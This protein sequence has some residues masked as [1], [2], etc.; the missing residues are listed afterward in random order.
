MVLTG[1]HIS[2]DTADVYKY[3]VVRHLF[4]LYVMGRGLKIS[5]DD[6]AF[7]KNVCRLPVSLFHP[8]LPLFK[9]PLCPVD[10]VF[11][12]APSAPDLAM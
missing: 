9:G 3:C 8:P 5:E 11:F 10:A 6:I 12:T 1:S 2:S 7:L 4:A